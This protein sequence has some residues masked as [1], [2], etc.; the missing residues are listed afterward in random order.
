MA[1]S[2]TSK[3]PSLSWS[4]PLG[5]ARLILTHPAYFWPFACLVILGDAILTQLIIRFI[6]YTEIDYA[7]YMVHIDL[8]L[9]GER[10]YSLI[11]GPTGL[12]VYPAGHVHIHRF[13]H[14]LTVTGSKITNLALA[15][16]VYGALYVASLILACAIY[17]EAGNVPNWALVL[18]VLSKR[19]H[20]IYVLRLFNDCWSVVALLASVY[21]LI[22]GKNSL[23]SVL[24][25]AALSV[26]MNI[27]LYLPGL[28]LILFKT[29]GLLGTLRHICTIV[30][31][32]ILVAL[33][34]LRTHPREYLSG[35]FNLS[36]AFLYKWT[37]NWRFFSEET[38]LSS[39]FSKVLLA[40]HLMTLV[41]FAIGKWCAPDGGIWRVIDRGIKRPSRGAGL[42]RVD[43]NQIAV[44][45]FTCNVIGITFA[46]SLH[47]QFY[48]WY[49]QQLPLLAWRTSYP[50]FVRLLLLGCIEYSWNVFPS[51]P[52]SSALLLGSNV[53]LLGGIFFG[54]SLDQ[55]DGRPREIKEE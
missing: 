30:L 38:F 37:V 41:A 21:A 27:L 23:G 13:L 25:S 28:L 42:A 20:S 12:L 49:A 36:R 46:R 3:P 43:A 9:A 6:Q 55:F 54:P 19:L 51:T 50:V 31:F 17:R 8:Y 53:L 34:F 39:P 33:P 11:T 16:Q 44:I 45:M 24:F 29:E 10:D 35:A 4:Q 5:T 7:T 14:W 2:S 32:Q 40:G 52:F 47:Y 26:K 22:K 15:Q 1:T 18:L 48:S